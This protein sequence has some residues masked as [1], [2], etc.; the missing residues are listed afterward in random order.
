MSV[1]KLKNQDKEVLKFPIYTEDGKDT[2]KYLKFDMGDIGLILKLND[3]DKK[4]KANLKYIRDQYQIIDKRED[5]QG[6]YLLTFN[7][8]EKAK[9]LKEF[10]KRDMEAIDLFL[11][12]NGC[13][14]ILEAMERDPYWDMFEDI[15]GDEGII[16]AIL[17]ELKIGLDNVA[18]KIKDKYST[19]EE[20][21]ILE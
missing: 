8:E 19:K 2:G 13:E 17:P 3:T 21:D 10:Y 14:T 12:K 4:H 16:A 20:T 7:Q 11:G 15:M 6:K 9:V 5:K 1:I 18:D